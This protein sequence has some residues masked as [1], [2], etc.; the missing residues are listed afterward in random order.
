MSG[1]F[2]INQNLMTDQML[3]DSHV[4]QLLSKCCNSEE[5][6]PELK[7]FARLLL[8]GAKVTKVD[9]KEL[10]KSHVKLAVITVSNNQQVTL[11]VR[12]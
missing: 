11:V 9:Y 1:Y 7:L 10:G 5:N 12:P 3:L 4:S 2:T 8:A 6:C